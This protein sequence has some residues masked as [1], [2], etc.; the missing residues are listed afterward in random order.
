MLRQ[1]APPQ[2]RE[3]Q[4]NHGDLPILS[5]TICKS[6]IKKTFDTILNI[7][8]FGTWASAK[9]KYSYDDLFHLYMVVELVG[10]IIAR[11]EKNQVIIMTSVPD[12][13]PPDKTLCLTIEDY[14]QKI[15]YGILKRI[16]INQMMIKAIDEYGNGRS[17]KRN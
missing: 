14:N 16:T 12:F 17:L 5:F 4:R 7:V 2:V 15:G 11:I 10:G 8:S 9:A 13:K 6:P 1:I 3:F